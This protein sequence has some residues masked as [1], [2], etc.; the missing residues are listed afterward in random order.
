MHHTVA[1]LVAATLLAQQE[2]A[3]FP[4]LS[5]NIVDEATGR[6]PSWLQPSAVFDV[7]GVRV[8]VIG[9]TVRTTP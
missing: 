6:P 3:N 7:N 9:A 4:F 5:A 2:R 1:V 8:G